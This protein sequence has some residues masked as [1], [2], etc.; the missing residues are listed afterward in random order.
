MK[1]Q[2][3]PI[4]SWRKMYVA[5]PAAAPAPVKTIPETAQKEETANREPVSMQEFQRKA[6]VGNYFAGPHCLFDPRLFR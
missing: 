5:Y 6:F 4:P 2:S 3:L 1:N